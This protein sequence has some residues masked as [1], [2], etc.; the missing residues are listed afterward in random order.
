MAFFNKIKKL[1][2]RIERL[3]QML[4]GAETKHDGEL[5]LKKLTIQDDEGRDRIVL[6][7]ADIS[8]IR[9]FDSNGKKRIS[10]GT[11]LDLYAGVSH[12]DANEKQRIAVGTLADG[13]AA[14]THFDANGNEQ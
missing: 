2:Q 5:T 14:V 6:A 1:E 9:W 3:E 10:A 8:E 12:Y 4:L 7:G 13:Q 11:V